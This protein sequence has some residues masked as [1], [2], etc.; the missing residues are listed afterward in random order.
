MLLT[1]YTNEF[2]WRSAERAELYQMTTHNLVHHYY[3][4]MGSMM[5]T[6]FI[7][8]GQW[9]SIVDVF[10]CVADFLPDLLSDWAHFDPS[11]IWCSR[12]FSVG[13]AAVIIFPFIAVQVDF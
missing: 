13:I 8:F 2:L 4:S 6:L 1:Y 11:S 12:S 7:C 9:T 3:G 5:T 10:I